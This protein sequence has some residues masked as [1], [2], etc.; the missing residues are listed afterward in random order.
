VDGPAG[1]EEL[2]VRHAVVL[3][4]GTEP[5]VPPIPGIHG[6]PCWTN[7]EAVRAREVPRSLVVLG[8]GAIGCEFAQVFRR[9][10]AEVTVVEAAERLLALEEPESSAVLADVFAAEGIDVR[11]GV[12]AT[13][14]AHTE[15]EDGGGFVVELED[16]STVRGERLLVATGRRADLRAVGLD[17]LGVDGS[18]PTAPVDEHLRV[19]EGVYAIGDVVGHGAYT[20]VSMHHAGVVAEVVRRV[21]A[22]ESLDGAPTAQP[23][24][25]PRVT[26]TDPE[27][28]GVGLTEQ[29]ARE[30][31]LSVRTGSTQVPSVARGWIHGVGNEGHLKLVADADRDV[32]VGATSMG[33][34]GG[35]VLAALSLAV[36]AEVPL[37]DLRRTIWAYPT[38]ARGIGDALRELG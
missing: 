24:A 7:R 6:T 34:T 19:A 4:P 9:F 23:H 18:L 28:G 35:E 16:G 2:A 15:A 36:S 38:I 10:G 33:P 32:L 3:D 20:H 13:R 5:V 27:V 31:G 25:V 11:T 37:A 29:Q 22:G 17:A 1:R 8:G 30:A 21:A 14:V 12:R 26:F